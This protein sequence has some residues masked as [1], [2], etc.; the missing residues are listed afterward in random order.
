VANQ[1][2]TVK[3]PLTSPVYQ[4]VDGIELTDNLYRLVNGYVDEM[5]AVVKRPGLVRAHTTAADIPNGNAV[6]AMKIWPNYSSAGDALFFIN[7]N[8]GSML[9]AAGAV[10]TLDGATT[11]HTSYHPRVSLGY[12]PGPAVSLFVA[13]GTTLRYHTAGA[14]YVD[15]SDA[16]CPTYVPDVTYLDGYTLV[17][18]HDSNGLRKSTF[19]WS[20]F[21]NGT[22]W[23]GTSR[24]DA[25]GEIDPIY[26]IYQH[27]RLL[28]LLGSRSTEI[29]EDDGV[30]PFSRISG[31]FI[32]LGCANVH[33]HGITPYGIFFIDNMR[34]LSYIEGAD[35]KQVSGPYDKFI[36]ELD[37][38]DYIYFAPIVVS[39]RE[40]LSVH[41]G[42]A[43]SETLSKTLIWDRKTG[44]WSEWTHYDTA[45]AER[46]LPIA[47]GEVWPGINRSYIG[48]V[49]S[50]G[51]P[52][53]SNRWGGA[54]Y[55]ASNLVYDA[56]D[57]DT[58]T[59]QFIPLSITSGHINYGTTKM[60]RSDEL[61]LILKRGTSASAGT[62]T[63]T[64]LD[65]NSRTTTHTINLGATGDAEIPVRLFRTG[66]FR[67]RQYTLTCSSD[68]QFI[69]AS[70]EEDI[71]VLRS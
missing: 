20:D 54:H 57:R 49:G 69:L 47:C 13:G 4:N 42:V 24:Q 43:G 39:G 65:D 50:T 67:T 37:S 38:L 30:T 15:V 26:G 66:A 45:G 35:I 36:S 25:M 48:L 71:T 53:F 9:S 19:Y 18:A 40:F 23:I 51:T 3:V 5:G 68:C 7:K 63:L 62:A 14:G 41:F 6:M 8:K 59:T 32:P 28:Y 58:S 55:F 2:T 64:I 52:V 60:K 1:T 29:W 33:S 44:N 70:A 56:L 21:Q 34:R 16:D 46:A 27:N 31:G 17:N 61:R 12:T 11:P 22:S 10:T